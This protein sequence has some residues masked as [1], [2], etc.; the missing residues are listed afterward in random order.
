MYFQNVKID[1]NTKV[2]FL[3]SEYTEEKPKIECNFA[4]LYTVRKS[5]TSLPVSE[6]MDIVRDLSK[7]LNLRLNRPL[8]FKAIKAQLI[9]RVNNN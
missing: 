8:E 6:M 5:A 3:P 9:N 4:I 1:Y 7:Q 2:V